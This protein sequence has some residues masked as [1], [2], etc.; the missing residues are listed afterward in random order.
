MNVRT[1]KIRLTRQAKAGGHK[2]GKFEE[3]GTP[4]TWS[5]HY[6][7]KC[8][9][10]GGYARLEPTPAPNS[11]EVY[12]TVFS[13]CAGPN[14]VMAHDKVVN[15]GTQATLRVGSDCY[16]YEVVELINMDVVRVRRLSHRVIK[17]GIEPTYEY[18]S[19]V[20]QP[21]SLVARR[22]YKSREVWV[23][24][25]E[26]RDGRFVADSSNSPFYFGY[27]RY[28]QDPHR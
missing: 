10:C 21:T 1:E 26:T 6:E 15:V 23:S 8:K 11:I 13:V 19:D 20:K 18:Y 2:L 5:H 17:P 16:P 22:T 9:L 24:A 25:C 27:A 28:Y 4:G 7:A 3:S 14:C 12:G